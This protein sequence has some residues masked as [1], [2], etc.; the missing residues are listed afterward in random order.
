MKPESSQRKSNLKKKYSFDFRQVSKSL[1][2]ID[3]IIKEEK[4]MIKKVD[5][6]LNNF[7]E[8]SEALQVVQKR[9]ILRETKL[10]KNLFKKIFA[11]KMRQ[12][13]SLASLSDDEIIRVCEYDDGVNY[14]QGLHALKSTR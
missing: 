10:K 9:S 3:Q 14:M 7:L 2:E 11:Q 12:I 8:I 4:K 13:S 5:N 1:N 6:P